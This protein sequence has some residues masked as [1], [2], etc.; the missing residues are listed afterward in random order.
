MGDTKVRRRHSALA[1]TVATVAMAVG[2]TALP[3]DAAPPTPDVDLVAVGDSYTAGTGATPFDPN[4]PCDQSPGGYVDRLA[5]QAIVDDVV[6]N[7]ACHGALLD[8]RASGVVP[9]VMEQI[10]ALAASER[11]SRGPSW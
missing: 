2:F 11:L 3:A 5:A 9:S 1:A 6:S 4:F 10:A 7:G 8:A